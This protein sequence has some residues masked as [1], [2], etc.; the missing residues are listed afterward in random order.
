MPTLSAGRP[1]WPL[2]NSGTKH[3]ESVERPAVCAR[4][5][6]RVCRLPD[7]RNRGEGSGQHHRDCRVMLHGNIRVR[8]CDLFVFDHKFIELTDK[9]QGTRRQSKAFI[10]LLKSLCGVRGNRAAI[11]VT[12]GYDYDSHHCRYRSSAWRRRLLRPWTLV[13][14]P[15]PSKSHSGRVPFVAG[16]S[17]ASDWGPAPNGPIEPACVPSRLPSG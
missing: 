17:E 5:G 3:G 8:G 15:I 6:M 4:S 16:R 2:Q 1:R 12:N 11:G 7:R 14:T 10:L 9:Q 13:L